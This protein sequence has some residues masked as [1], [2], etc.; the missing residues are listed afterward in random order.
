VKTT[1][2]SIAKVE[3]LV[4]ALGQSSAIMSMTDMQKL[5]AVSQQA[6]E[7]MV[8]VAETQKTMAETQDGGKLGL[9]AKVEFARL[10]LRLKGLERKGK[11][12]AD[13]AIQKVSKMTEDAEASVLEVLREAARTK[14]GA[15]DSDNL[16]K[17][18][19]DG[20]NEVSLKQFQ[21]FFSIRAAEIEGESAAIAL[22][23]I[24]PHGLTR[25][26]L[27]AALQSY[28]SCIK[29][30]SLTAEFEVQSAK[31]L[32]KIVVGEP[33]E[34]I[35]PVKK[36]SGL[37]L[38]RVQCRCLKDGVT[39]WATVKSQSGTTYL[40]STEKPYLWCTDSMKLYKEQRL[41]SKTV[42]ALGPGEVVELVQGPMQESVVA[43]QRVRGMACHEGTQ[44]WLQIK[45][46]GGNILAKPSARVFKCVESIAMTDVSDFEN[47]NMVRKIE[48]DEALELL[49]DNAVSPEDGGQ[50]KR[51][52][53]CRDGK[54]GWITTEGS[55]GTIYVKPAAKHYICS[56]AAPLHQALGAESSVARVLMPGEAF[57]AFEDPKEVSGGEKQTTYLVKSCVQPA[58]GWLFL[59]R[60]FDRGDAVVSQVPRVESC[61]TH[62][63]ARVQRGCRN[64]RGDSAVGARGTGR[65]S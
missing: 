37:G 57:A 24:A 35:G 9:D 12:I 17:Q 51:F 27:A 25:R 23:K 65:C 22:K 21:D 59:W 43:G 62:Q 5:E 19:G 56:Q 6:K 30:I 31:K 28:Y 64:N 46:K 61:S 14:D 26:T 45:D 42:R 63:R 34:A 48:A 44:G 7:A 4:S 3:K 20:S 13:A 53:A 50:R 40:S 60:L 47:C 10:Q 16:F 1:A 33:L 36:D 38:E 8:A 39:G 41:D 58:E 15:I 18:L 54:E 55:Q 49:P 11:A 52:R 29:E 2:D 32:R